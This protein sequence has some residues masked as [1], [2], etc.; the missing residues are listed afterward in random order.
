[1]PCLIDQLAIS[2]AP[3]SV[4]SSS[5]NDS[6]YVVETRF[7]FLVLCGCA[8]L[9]R[10]YIADAGLFALLIAGRAVVVSCLV[11][12]VCCGSD[13]D[14]V[15]RYGDVRLSNISSMLLIWASPS[16]PIPCYCPIPVEARVLSSWR[17][18]LPGRPC[19]FVICY[20]L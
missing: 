4:Y 3:S 2:A 19:I 15:V 9:V 17:G 18:L 6:M 11:G 5:T 7:L 13:L 8:S 14:G 1:M 16:D 20:L 12:L 10:R